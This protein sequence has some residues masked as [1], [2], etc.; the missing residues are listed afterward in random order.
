MNSESRMEVKRCVLGDKSEKKHLGQQVC[1]SETR[2]LMIK[3]QE[4]K[5][6]K[7]P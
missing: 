3:T 1:S 4:K 7:T 2:G 6:R 5:G